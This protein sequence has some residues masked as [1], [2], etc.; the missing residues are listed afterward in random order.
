MYCNTET[1]HDF[2]PREKFE[3]QSCDAPVNNNERVIGYVP[4]P[5]EK[6]KQR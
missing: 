1:I 4:S 5:V 3:R 2:K 6:A